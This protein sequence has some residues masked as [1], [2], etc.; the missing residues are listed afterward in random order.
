[1]VKTFDNVKQYLNWK[2]LIQLD[3]NYIN[4]NLGLRENAPIN[5][6]AAESQAGCIN[7]ELKNTSNESF[8]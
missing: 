4:V 6:M 3:K 1:M 5:D 8:D 2:I 7:Y